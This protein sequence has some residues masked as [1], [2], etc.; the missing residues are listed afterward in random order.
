MLTP[1]KIGRQGGSATLRQSIASDD[2]FLYALFVEQGLQRLAFLDAGGPQ[3]PEV[4]SLEYQARLMGR[5]AHYPTATQYIVLLQQSVPA[6]Q[7]L[8]H[9]DAC[10]LR[11][12]ELVLADKYRGQGLGTAVLGHVQCRARSA[13]KIVRL[14]VLRDSPAFR[15]YERCEF[16][17]VDVGELFVEMEWRPAPSFISSCV[18]RRQSE[19]GHHQQVCCE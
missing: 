12:V 5:E 15:L 18:L 11:I 8:L 3:L 14:Q 6:G 9:E 16:T 13:G 10:A 7:M 4:L 2:A 17:S 19:S 1:Y